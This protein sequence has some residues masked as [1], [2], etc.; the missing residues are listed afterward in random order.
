MNLPRPRTVISSDIVNSSRGGYPRHRELKSAA[1]AALTK[2][3][4]ECRYP[5][6]WIRADRGDGELTLLPPDIPVAWVLTEFLEKLRVVILDYNY[7]KNT[8]HKLRLRPGIEFGDVVIDEAGAVVQGGDP[9]V[10]ASRMRDSAPAREATV[11]VP[12]APVVVLVSDA[13]YGRTVPYQAAG[14]QA[15]MFRR[16]RA[17][18][19]DFSTVAWL[20]VPGHQPPQVTGSAPEPEPE[21]ATPATGE[22]TRRPVTPPPTGTLARGVQIHGDGMTLVGDHQQHR[23][24]N[25]SFGRG[26]S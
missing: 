26:S 19:K 6:S 23:F 14:L 16:V 20:H 4:Q 22:P 8:E 24:D 18:E 17:A 3:E 9:V 21:P 15:A 12:A 10:A 5:G 7:N 25:V 1:T 11:A 13:V 2:V